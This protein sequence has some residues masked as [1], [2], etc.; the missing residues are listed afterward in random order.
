MREEGRGGRE[1]VPKRKRKKKRMGDD[2]HNLTK[3]Q[4][5]TLLISSK[6][7]RGS[8]VCMPSIYEEHEGIS[9]PALVSISGCR[10]SMR[11][12]RFEPR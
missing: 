7:D 12:S 8:R 2:D 11:A 5:L 10:M 1:E 9:R 3:L 6:K 4:Q